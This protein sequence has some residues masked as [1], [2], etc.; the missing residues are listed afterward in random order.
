MKRILASAKSNW[1]YVAYGYCVVMVV[2]ALWRY[3]H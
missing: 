1:R 2:M 3:C